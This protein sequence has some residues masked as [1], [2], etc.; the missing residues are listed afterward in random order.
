MGLMQVIGMLP[1]VSRSGS[2]I[3]GGI[4]YGIDREKAARFSFLMSIP[5]IIGANLFQGLDLL[6]KQVDIQ[7]LPTIIGTVCAAIAGY[8]AIKF[9]LAL[10]QRKKLYGFC[11]ICGNTWDTNT[12]G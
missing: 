1:G 9:M 12:G 6:K 11:D 8:I 3:A 5:A 7:W 2:T 4:A 10:I